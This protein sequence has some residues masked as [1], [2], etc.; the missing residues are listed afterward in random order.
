MDFNRSDI[1]PDSVW[2]TT[3]VL[4]TPVHEGKGL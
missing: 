4:H 2:K 1:T 3:L